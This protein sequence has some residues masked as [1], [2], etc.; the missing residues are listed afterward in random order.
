[1]KKI[2]IAAGAL[3][4]AGCSYVLPQNSQTL[5]YQCGTT[6]LTVA[7]DGKESTVSL[8]MD[9][10]QLKLKQ[11]LAMTGAKYSDGKYTFWSKGQNAYLERNGKVIMSDCTL[12]N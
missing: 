6:P 1:M 9:G 4:L 5:H 10:E 3:A 7:L 12:A 11:V 2:I 8:L